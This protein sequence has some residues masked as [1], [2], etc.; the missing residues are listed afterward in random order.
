M[1]KAGKDK[2]MCLQD[3]AGKDSVKACV[4]VQ[5]KGI[6]Y[7]SPAQEPLIKDGKGEKSCLLDGGKGSVH[8]NSRGDSCGMESSEES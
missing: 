4:K 3:I 1:L 8:V 7:E 2:T 5:V 6:K